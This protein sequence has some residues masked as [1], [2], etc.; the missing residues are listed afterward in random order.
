MNVVSIVSVCIAFLSFVFSTVW[1]FNNAKKQKNKEYTDL[2]SAIKAENTEKT[3]MQVLFKEM[4]KN[5]E[6]IVEDNK[7]MNERIYDLTSRVVLLEHDQKNISDIA[8]QIP[9]LDNKANKAHQRIDVIEH[10]LEKINSI[11]K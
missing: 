5:L 3:E 4:N 6:R 11:N 9:I 8:G 7:V 2:I 10:D 1:S